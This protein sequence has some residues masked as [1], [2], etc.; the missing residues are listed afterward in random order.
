MSSFVDLEHLLAPLSGKNRVG[1]DV[2]FADVTM[3]MEEARRADEVYLPRA[4]WEGEK[5]FKEA[6]WS[7]LED[8][9]TTTLS[10]RSKDLP[11][12]CWLGEA[13]GH[14]YGFDGMTEGIQLVN[15]L[16]LDYWDD[17]Y[18]S[19]AEDGLEERVAK[20]TWLATTFG[21][22]VR[23]TPIT[24]KS[25]GGYSWNHWQESRDFENLRR[26]NPTAA[27]QATA[28]GKI[29]PEVFDSAV[30]NSSGEFYFALKDRVE[31]LKTA[32]VEFEQNLD[33]KFE[34]NSPNLSPL[35]EALDQVL[36]A[37]RGIFK[38]KGL[39]SRESG[40]DESL[41]ALSGDLDNPNVTNYTNGR[42]LDS[43]AEALRH[44]SEIADFFARTETHSPVS[45][46]IQRAVE[47]ADMP[48]HIWLQEVIKEE[49]ILGQ[50]RETLGVK[51]YQEGS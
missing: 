17:L 7:K 46:L 26:H 42:S 32:C 33:Q 44:L 18:P 29:A 49:T 45:Y 34:V 47:W 9:A 40:T 4:E 19:L 6:D 14:H 10:E 11:T 43:R 41:N 22:I 8:L 30:A 5:E 48:L 51:P 37:I 39:H 15:R 27:E 20:I 36:L 13:L 24:D 2:R 35:N 50:V 21:E 16:L 3:Q 1:E 38:Q 23:A 25:S 28:D 12:A 31:K